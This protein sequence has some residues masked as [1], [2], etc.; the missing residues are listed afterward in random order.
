MGHGPLE[1]VNPMPK[2][3]IMVKKKILINSRV[4]ISNMTK[5]FFQIPVKKNSNKVFLVPSLK[6]S[7]FG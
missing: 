5:V 4:L 2:I 3:T 1:K 6:F 7:C